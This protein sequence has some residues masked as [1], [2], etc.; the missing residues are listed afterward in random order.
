M[1]LKNILNSRIKGITA[2]AIVI[3]AAYLASKFLGLYRDHLLAGTFGAGNELD[4]YY[5]A[6][7]IPDLVYY[8]VVLGAVS[9]G[10]IPVFVDYLQKEK[11]EAWYLINN[12]INIMSLVLIAVCSLL[13]IAAPWLMKLIVPGFINE[14]TIIANEEINKLDLTVQ[15]TRIMFLSPILLGLS[16]IFGGVIQSFRRFFIFAFAPILY[17][18]GIIIG[19]IV[20]Y[21][22][23]GLLGLAW[24]V[25]LGALLHFIAQYFSARSCGFKYQ[26]V[27]D[28]KFKGIKRILK[29]MLPRTLGLA[30]NQLNILLMTI[31]GSTLAIGSIAVY[32]LAQNIWSFP[33]SVFGISFVTASFPKLSEEA[34]KKDVAIERTSVPT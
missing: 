12:L 11:E 29:V 22:V 32:N 4:A 30:L 25:V 14:V 24:G 5:A 13:I 18:F 16:A 26:F 15:L 8:L 10:L 3:G 23:F 9:A 21:P 1:T 20:F 17:N 33:L 19:V 2:A 28:Y 31:I 6:F 34:Q 27:F 7:R